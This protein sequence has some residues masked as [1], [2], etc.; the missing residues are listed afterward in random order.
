MQFSPQRHKKLLIQLRGLYIEL[1]VE[2]F[3]TRKFTKE[4]QTREKYFKRVYQ[5]LELDNME[6]EEVFMI[7]ALTEYVFR[8]LP[9]DF[10][11]SQKWELM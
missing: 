5:R 10:R 6:N 4:G 3:M 2:E 8:S 9:T 11:D 1:F 7:G